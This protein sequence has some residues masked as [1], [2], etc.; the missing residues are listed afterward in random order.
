MDP[1]Q[2]L[3]PILDPLRV[4]T[5]S[6]RSTRSITAINEHTVRFDAS[7]REVRHIEFNLVGERDKFNCKFET[8]EGK[9][10]RP[11]LPSNQ[12]VPML[13]PHLLHE[14]HI[15]GKGFPLSRVLV[16]NG[17]YKNKTPFSGFSREFFP[18]LYGQKY[19][20]P[21]KIRVCMR[22]PHAFGGGGG[23]GG[24]GKSR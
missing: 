1:D 9:N 22:P 14:P 8:L 20:F 23:A 24:K 18:R 7:T 15:S 2:S 3:R 13:T 10:T 17:N 12:G 5:S 6:G 19:P 4:W 16:T 21:E 11:P